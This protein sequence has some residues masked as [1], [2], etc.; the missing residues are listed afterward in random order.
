MSTPPK[1]VIL[2][3]LGS[4]LDQGLSAQRWDRWRPTV[5]LGQHP[6][7]LVDR[8]DLLHSEAHKRLADIVVAD[9]RIVS[10]ETTVVRHPFAVRD[11]WDFEEVYAALFDFARAYPFD[12]EKE[13]YLVH[14]TTGTHVIQICLFLLIESGHI[15]AKLIQTGLSPRHEANPAGTYG[16]IDLDLSR[17]DKLAERF[18]QQARGDVSFLKSGIETKNAAFNAMI[19]RIENVGAESEA[20][21]LL[22]GPTGAGKS[23]LARLI[24]ELRK[25]RR[26][27]K[28]DF[29]E[30]NCATLRGDAAMSTLFGHKKGAF[31]GAMADRPGLLRQADGGVLF[32][33]EIGELGS[34]E[35][36][37]LLRAIESK[38][39]YPLGAD[40]E[41]SSDFQLICGSNRLLGG[42]AATGAF[43]ENLLARINIWT[44]RLP[45]L[46][47]RPEDIEPNLDYELNLQAE[48]SGKLTRFNREAREL[49]LTLAAS[50]SAAWR[51]NFRDLSA[52]VMRMAALARGG[53]ISTDLV[54]EEWERL[55]KG[56]WELSDPGATR[57][58]ATGD[59]VGDKDALPDDAALLRDILG[60]RCDSL[61]LF[62]RPQLACAVRICRESRSLSEAGRTLF[63]ESRKKKVH[64]NDAD[65]L[66][67]YL[68][69]FGL[70]WESVR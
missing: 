59:A 62:D 15:P 16:I 23:R 34:D 35:Q 27:V 65:R 24:Y 51:G 12:T 44:F 13:E 54:H 68:A 67:K 38:R 31:T 69:S 5:A 18:K 42:M 11:P 25:K 50:P 33:D 60:D 66:R 21:I 14:I 41:V 30:V 40:E 64:P 29:V 45:G 1:T 10:P 8:I 2:G 32:L 70:D 56:W 9:L 22:T 46:A 63:A 55:E 43:R 6:D 49:F 28:G 4:T 39:F 47:E 37:M 58:D 19:E 20:P 36:A 17:Y 7:L 26:L 48:R 57:G 52:G 3:M 61:D 53:R